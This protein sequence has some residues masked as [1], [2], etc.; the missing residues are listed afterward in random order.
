MTESNEND[1][2]YPEGKLNDDDEGAIATVIGT[3][4]TG[5]VFMQWPAPVTWIAF[6]PDQA[7]EVADTIKKHAEEARKFTKS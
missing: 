2:Q 5:E 6:S 3:T 7:D 4:K 1:P